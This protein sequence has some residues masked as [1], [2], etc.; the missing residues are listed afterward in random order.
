MYANTYLP[1]E[2]PVVCPE[3]S[4]SPAATV[5]YSFS[6]ETEAIL[7]DENWVRGVTSQ[8]EAI[9]REFKSEQ[10][11]PFGDSEV[12]EQVVALANSGGGV[13]LL[14]VEDDGSITGARNRHESCTDGDRL[15]A[16]I[17]N[18]T[19]PSISAECSEVTI[20]DGT[21]VVIEVPVLQGIFATRTGKY[22]RRQLRADGRP[23]SAPSSRS[24][25]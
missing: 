11:R 17:R 25:R 21:V 14:G 9:E 4:C 13:L 23:E 7:H 16:A 10:T 24:T 2:K 18:N 19:H 5:G 6:V 12:Y 22:L 3:P 20:T 1:A 8:G 15:S